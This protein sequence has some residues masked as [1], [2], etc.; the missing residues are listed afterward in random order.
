MVAGHSHRPTLKQ[1]SDSYQFPKPLNEYVAVISKINLSSLGTRPSL[2]SRINQKVFALYEAFASLLPELNVG[3]VPRAS[4]KA[5]PSSNA[6]QTR[7]N[8]KNAAKQ[9]QQT[10]RQALVAATRVFSGVDGAPR[11]VAVIPLCPDVDAKQVV[12]TL[13]ESI[14]LKDESDECPESG[15]YRIR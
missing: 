13:A 6:A 3:R 2:Q 4:V 5:L 1:V 15:L 10:K 12:L 7:L 14:G 8:R 9:A 11:I